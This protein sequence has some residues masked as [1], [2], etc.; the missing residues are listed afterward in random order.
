MLRFF[1]SLRRFDPRRPVR[2]WLYR[3]VRNLARDRLR[4][5]RVRRA[6]SLEELTEARGNDLPAAGPGPEATASRRQLQSV[7]WRAVQELPVH[8]RE[9][10][11]LRDYHGLAYAEIARILRLPRGTVMSRLHRGRLMVRQAVHAS[12]QTGLAGEEAADA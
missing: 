10:L 12:M 2:P 4:R 11:I 9:V 5:A 6:S 1:R 7:V 8:Y 3:I